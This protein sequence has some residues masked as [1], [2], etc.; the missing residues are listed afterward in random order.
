MQT[1][2]LTNERMAHVR[3]LMMLTILRHCVFG[4]WEHIAGINLIRFAQD[5]ATIVPGMT[6]GIL[7]NYGRFGFEVW[8]A[9]VTFCFFY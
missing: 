1:N 3:R 7:M 8:I 9:S 5:R 2:E 6:D 4:Y